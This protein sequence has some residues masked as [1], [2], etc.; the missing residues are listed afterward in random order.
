MVLV[1]LIVILVIRIRTH[2]P[3]PR[4]L[5]SAR[6]TLANRFSRVDH[7]VLSTTPTPSNDYQFDN[8][9]GSSVTKIQVN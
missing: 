5:E 2:R 7:G 6:R 1:I 8:P 3:I 4:H 9:S